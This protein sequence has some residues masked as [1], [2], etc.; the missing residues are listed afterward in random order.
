[1]IALI[2]VVIAVLALIVLPE[3]FGC[4]IDDED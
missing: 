3:V 2:V 1:M 4:K